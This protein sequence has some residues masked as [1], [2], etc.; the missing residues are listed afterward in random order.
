MTDAFSFNRNTLF[1]LGEGGTGQS[2]QEAGHDIA[3]TYYTAV[4]EL[5]C[6]LVMKNQV[7]CHSLNLSADFD[8]DPYREK[9][10]SHCLSC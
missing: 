6:N 9:L 2:A 7:S 1:G 4:T 10:E 5:V 3:Y 8:V